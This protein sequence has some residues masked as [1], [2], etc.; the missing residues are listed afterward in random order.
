MSG[1]NKGMEFVYPIRTGEISLTGKR[2]ALRC[3]HCNGLY[4]RDVEREDPKSYLVTGGCDAEG[5]V[6][7]AEKLD[8]LRQLARRYK[9][10]V[11]TGLMGEESAK[12]VAPFVEAASFN[13][14]CDDEAIR[15]VYGLRK[16]S[17]DYIESY[18]ALRRHIKVFPHI[19]LGI[20]RGR[21]IGEMKAVEALDSLGA[22][23]VV[24]NLLVPTRGTRY[25]RVQPPEVRA[26]TGV[27]RE[28]QR[29]LGAPVYLGC[30]RP[31]GRYRERIDQEAMRL[32]MDRIV[33]PS[34]GAIRLAKGLVAGIRD[35]CC[36]L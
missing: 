15:E 34:R 10:I 7:L 12:K 8:A 22:P 4:L 30:M 29:R 32:G 1:G 11:H 25:A 24:F 20:N 13:F 9:L 33:M 35:E 23:A 28:A 31:G 17:E 36:V 18:S 19:T 14:L 21:I 16:S 2:C 6:P 5:E 27:L 3:A 26:V